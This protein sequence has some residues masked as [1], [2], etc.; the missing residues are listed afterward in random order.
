ML[1]K[2]ITSQGDTFDSISKYFYG[3]E[4]Y[5]VNLIIG[6]PKY[7]DIV[8]FSSGIELIIPEIETTADEVSSTSPWR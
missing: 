6:N 2:Y 1:T 3:N 7:A 4:K 5:F 8:V